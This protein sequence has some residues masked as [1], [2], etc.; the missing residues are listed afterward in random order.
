MRALLLS[1]LLVLSASTAVAQELPLGA[2]LPLRDATFSK[3]DG[4]AA[5]LSSLAGTGGTLVMYWDAGCLWVERY[6]SRYEAL[7][8]AAQEARVQTVIL[9]PQAASTATLQVPENTQVLLDPGTLREALGAA[10]APH[11]FLFDAAASLQYVGAID[12]S[13]SN[14][15]GVRRPF[16]LDAISALR[17]GTT[18]EV[19]RTEP[20]GCL[21]RP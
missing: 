18:P 2:T 14:P 12:D 16:L 6:R 9:L 8:Q 11:I 17:N 7:V 1:L 19:T 20:I 10:R 3:R 15:A 13:P 5:T 4:S 21:L